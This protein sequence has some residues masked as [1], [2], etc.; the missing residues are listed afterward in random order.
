MSNKFDTLNVYY[1][2]IFIYPQAQ[3]LSEKQLCY[4]K[5]DIYWQ[6]CLLLIPVL[7]FF[8]VQLQKSNP[9][10]LG[11]LTHLDLEQMHIITLAHAKILLN[12]INHFEKRRRG[13]VGWTCLTKHRKNCECCPVSDNKDCQVL[14]CQ[15]CNQCLKCHNSLVLS[16]PLSLLLTLSQRSQVK[17]VNNKKSKIFK[18]VK[19]FFA[20]RGL[21]TPRPSISGLGLQNP[22]PREI[23]RSSGDVFPNT[24]LFLAVHVSRK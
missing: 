20:K 4:N 13:N 14:N 12:Q 7:H 6:I 11:K 15:N 3:T 5:N 2:V 18:R 22:H 23:S 24:S 10:I 19:V 17:I 1:K 9:N 16:S 21:V 8:P